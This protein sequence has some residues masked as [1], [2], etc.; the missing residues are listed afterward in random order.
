[1]DIRVVIKADI[2]AD[3][4]E[5]VRYCAHHH[6]VSFYLFTTFPSKDLFLFSELNGMINVG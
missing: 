6:Y 3:M 2:K 5:E 1:M 4:E